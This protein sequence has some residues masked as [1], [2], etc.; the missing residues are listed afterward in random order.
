VDPENGDYQLGPGSACADKGNDAAVPPDVDTDLAGEPRFVDA[1]ADGEAT[2]DLGAYEFPETCYGVEIH[3]PA[4]YMTIQ[5]AIDVA[6]FNDEIIVQ[7]DVYEEVINLRGK[8]ITLRGSGG[9]D[10]TTIDG[11]GLD[12]SV[13]VC[14][15]GE[16]ADTVI[17]GFTI[18]GGTGTW[19]KYMEDKEGGGMLVRRASPAVVD[20]RFVANSVAGLGGDARGGAVCIQLGSPTFTDCV[21]EENSSEH[22]GG[23]VC[24]EAYD[25]YGFAASNPTF[26]GCDFISNVASDDGG[27]IDAYID[28]ESTLAFSDCTYSMNSSAD[29][30]GAMRLDGHGAIGVSSCAFT[31]NAAANAGGAALVYVDAEGI[32]F[33]ACSFDS[34]QAHFGGALMCSAG[35]EDADLT[36]DHCN[37]TGNLGDYAG[38]AVMVVDCSLSLSNC[39]FTQNSS[40]WGGA[41][42][43][44]GDDANY[45]ITATDCTFAQNDAD[46]GGGLYCHDWGVTAL[47]GC[48]F[49]NNT[50]YRGAGLRISFAYVDLID[51]SFRENAAADIGGG[52]GNLEGYLTVG[53]TLF[54]ANQPDHIEGQFV[55]GDGNQFL[56]ECPID[57]PG[58][59]TGD[60]FVN[61]DDLFAVLGAWGD[62]DDCAEDTNQDGVVN[63]DDLFAVLGSWGPCP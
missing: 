41:V 32:S 43:G 19:D 15:G 12:S 1:D 62:C 31:D 28:G 6:C 26:S 21:F 2:V 33:T 20:C 60:E 58:D 9:R 16:D 55:D 38:G 40:A 51:C 30:G 36:V 56:D 50:A 59:V 46:Y 47:I 4:E 35:D 5:E 49:I 34:N 29:D 53:T 17:E 52:V 42:L 27:A 18:T 24:V 44:L 63:I 39:E 54:C 48:D 57:C 25:T 3:V 37:F 45:F 22:D 61:I 13:I 7:P 14:T 23:A 10:V 11:T 8:P